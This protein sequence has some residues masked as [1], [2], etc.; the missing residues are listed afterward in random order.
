MLRSRASAQPR[1][2][3]KAHERNCPSRLSPSSFA[4]SI[5]LSAKH[6][7]GADAKS[8]PLNSDVVP[9]HCL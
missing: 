3:R 8:A 7:V 4:R 2:R 1:W 5:G 6:F 9:I